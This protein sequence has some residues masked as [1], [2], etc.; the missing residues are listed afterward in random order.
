MQDPYATCGGKSKKG[1]SFDIDTNNKTKVPAYRN[2][3]F[4]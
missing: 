2:R 4:R 1:A 3:K